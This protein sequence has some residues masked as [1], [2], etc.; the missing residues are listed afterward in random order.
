MGRG[1]YKDNETRVS[2][3]KNMYRLGV[4]PTLHCGRCGVLPIVLPM[5]K[6]VPHMVTMG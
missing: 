6:A 2:A 3:L 1:L 4:S 5:K